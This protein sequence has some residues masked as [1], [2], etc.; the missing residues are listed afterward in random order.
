[1]TSEDRQAQ[2]DRRFDETFAVF[3]E[4]MRK[5]QETA[6]QQR[7]SRGSGEVAGAGGESGASGEGGDT[8]SGQDPGTGESG[9]AGS[10]ESG[11]R[12]QTAG[13]GSN[14]PG[15]GGG[16][17]GGAKGGAGPNTVPA[18]IPDGSDDDIVAR[19]LREAAMKETDPE[20]R[21]RLWD[22]YRKYKQSTS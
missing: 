17:G 6:S 1:M 13:S 10:G 2:I 16:Y 21:E 9:Q 11:G 8:G 4:R 12:G 3:D 20:L 18:D 14:T 5:E 7:A 22:E 19:Q 15:G